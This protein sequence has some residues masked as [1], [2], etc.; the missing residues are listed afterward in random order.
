MLD[1]AVVTISITAN[2]GNVLLDCATADSVKHG[3][4]ATPQHSS[5]TRSCQSSGSDPFLQGGPSLPYP[6][7]PAPVRPSQSCFDPSLPPLRCFLCLFLRSKTS[8]HLPLTQG[9]SCIQAPFSDWFPTTSLLSRWALAHRG[10][11]GKISQSRREGSS[12]GIAPV[13]PLFT[14]MREAPTGPRAS[15]KVNQGHRGSIS[16]GSDPVWG[17]PGLLVNWPWI[18]SHYLC[19]Y[20]LFFF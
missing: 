12:G 4:G 13:P 14:E 16:S 6:S 15:L 20:R 7:P 8:P 5:H 18:T 1:R 10:R 17:Y 9:P 3:A 11:L 19:D 2:V